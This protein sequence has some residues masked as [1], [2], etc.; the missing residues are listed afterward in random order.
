MLGAGEKR[1]VDVVEEEK[2]RGC[3]MCLILIALFKRSSV[4]YSTIM[5]IRKL[6]TAPSRPSIRQTRS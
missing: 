3:V 5:I 4:V 6:D 1:V 2:S